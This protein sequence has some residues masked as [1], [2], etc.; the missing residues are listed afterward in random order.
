MKNAEMDDDIEAGW[1][2]IDILHGRQRQIIQ[3][4]YDDP[5]NADSEK[6]EDNSHLSSPHIATPLQ[7]LLIPAPLR[8]GVSIQLNDVLDK[9]PRTRV[10]MSN[11]KGD[12]ADSGDMLDFDRC[13]VESGCR[14]S[15][16]RPRP[17]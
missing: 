4:D 15:R 14:P 5:S 12:A 11:R 8:V 13:V 7:H 9:Y 6:Q 17:F 2:D 1:W 16:P 3:T 10:F